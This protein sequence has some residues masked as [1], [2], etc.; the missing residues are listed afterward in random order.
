[1]ADRFDQFL[2]GRGVE[3]RVHRLPWPAISA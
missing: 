1:V 3:L 2:L